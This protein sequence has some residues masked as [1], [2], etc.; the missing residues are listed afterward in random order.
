MNTKKILMI[1]AIIMT[2]MITGC[3]KDNV[4]MTNDLLYRETN[5]VH[6]VSAISQ[7]Q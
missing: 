1:I 2:V 6:K 7:Y 5:D 4:P 3:T